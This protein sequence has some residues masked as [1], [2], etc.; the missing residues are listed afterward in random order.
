MKN[1]FIPSLILIFLIF[2]TPSEA[3]LVEGRTLL[4]SELPQVQP[5]WAGNEIVCTGTLVGPRVVLTAAH[6][7]D[8]DMSFGPA[9]SKTKII[10]FKYHPKYWGPEDVNRPDGLEVR[11]DVAIGILENEVPAISPLTIS[12]KLPALGDQVLI[13]GAGDPTAGVR[14]IARVGVIK[15]SDQGISSRDSDNGKSY[16][17]FGDSGGATLSS[18]QGGEV[19]II[20]VIS[21]STQD[22]DLSRWFGE[23]GKPHTMGSYLVYP[24]HRKDHFLKNMASKFDLRIC[25]VNEVCQRVTT[26]LK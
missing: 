15:V 21:T 10:K 2:T 6:C 24:S 12:S 13:A 14:K 25:G 8:K 17:S 9:S 3:R 22:Q 19:E 7:E 16:A 5:I 26:P 20:G 18:G 1:T 23:V 11:Y 4:D